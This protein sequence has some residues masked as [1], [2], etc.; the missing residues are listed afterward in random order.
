MDEWYRKSYRRNLVDMHIEDWNPEFLSA[1]DPNKYVEMMKIANVQ[2]AMIYANS[3][4]GYC[5]WPTQ[6]GHMHAGLGGRDILAEVLGEIRK[7]EMDPVLYYSLIY[8]NWAYEKHPDWRMVDVN[9]LP[10]RD[11]RHAWSLGDIHGGR[12]GHCCPNS[13]GYRDFL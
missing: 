3:H 5:Y 2:T 13:Q 8:N 6:S 12:Y 9:G 4:I 11:P 7:Q 10:S 1:F